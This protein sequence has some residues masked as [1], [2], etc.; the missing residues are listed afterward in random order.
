MQCDL[1]EADFFLQLLIY[2]STC[3]QLKIKELFLQAR[4]CLG[5]LYMN[6][7]TSSSRG[8]ICKA[9][10]VFVVPFNSFEL[11]HT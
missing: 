11:G 2:I 8:Q 1:T 7:Y 9:I 3:Q 6:P 10:S 5:P 4:D